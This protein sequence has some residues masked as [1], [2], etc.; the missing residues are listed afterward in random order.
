MKHYILF[1]CC[2]LFINFKGYADPFAAFLVDDVTC[3][4][5]AARIQLKTAPLI[6]LALK[7]PS[8][9]TETHDLQ[10]THATLTETPRILDFSL[11]KQRDAESS[12]DTCRTDLHMSLDLSSMRSESLS[13]DLLKAESLVSKC[14]IHAVGIRIMGRRIALSLKINTSDLLE[15]EAILVKKITKNPHISIVKLNSKQREFTRLKPA[16]IGAQKAKDTCQNLSFI[17]K[18]YTEDMRIL[19]SRAASSSAAA[20]MDEDSTSSPEPFQ[21]K[22]PL[23]KGSK[24]AK[25]SPLKPENRRLSP[26]KSPGEIIKKS[27]PSPT[28]HLSR[29]SVSCPEQEEACLPTRKLP[30]CQLFSTE[31]TTSAV[32]KSSEEAR[33]LDVLTRRRHAFDHEI[34]TYARILAEELA[35]Q[36]EEK[37]RGPRRL[38][39]IIGLNDSLIKMAK[40]RTPTK[41][42]GFLE[43]LVFG[44]KVQLLGILKG[45]LD[46]D[47]KENFYRGK[48]SISKAEH[49]KI[50]SLEE[51]H[52][53]SVK[54]EELRLKILE[55][56]LLK[57]YDVEYK[58]SPFNKNLSSLIP[59][60]EIWESW[61]SSFNQEISA[62]P[63]P[64]VLGTLDKERIL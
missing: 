24:V 45:A 57:L 2:F 26:A 34:E 44:I 23:S 3:R 51:I 63:L 19:S 12:E 52:P 5:I 16:E 7:N 20:P 1:T 49:G 59:N 37:L 47:Q 53:F 60:G 38:P 58:E 54:E 11:T 22:S 21:K 62:D 14:P 40:D 18:N 48:E 42:Q 29:L 15:D 36:I 9:K 64:I 10:S 50:L 31:A 55:A 41:D 43:S 61:I 25:K 46:T 33:S 35:K 32:D 17:F 4:R 30:P 28:T 56:Y 39:S 27:N 6:E 13:K 8:Y